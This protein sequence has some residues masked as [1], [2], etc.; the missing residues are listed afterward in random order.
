M[1]KLLLYCLVCFLLGRLSVGF[2]MYIGPDENKYN[3]AT[4]GILL[5]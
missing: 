3:A 1:Y 4:I 2:K 5:K